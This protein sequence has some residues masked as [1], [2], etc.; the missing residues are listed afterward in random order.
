MARLS[1]L[2]RF[3]AP[4]RALLGLALLGLAVWVL[5][6]KWSELSGAGAFLARP[7]WG[8]LVL[9]AVAELASFMSLAAL[10]QTLM[11]AGEVRRPLRRF[12]AITF[13]GNSVQ[14]ALPVGAAFAGLYIFRQYQ[15]LGADDVLAG[16]VVIG[17][18]VVA[19][20]AI[21]G[22]AGVALALAAST[23]TTFDLFE[24]IAGVLAVALMAVLAW[25]YRAR[26]YPWVIKAVRGGRKNRASAS[27]QAERANEACPGPHA[28]GRAVPRRL[29]PGVVRRHH[30]LGR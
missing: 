13:A 20:S 21:A 24:A 23:G 18:S 12:A 11:T 5:S 9:A 28:D 22:L 27:G 4:F 1:N 15:F 3:W 6:G 30:R 2:R 19:F 17:T 29:A 7:H 16:W 10:E 8:W 26:L 14:S 25:A